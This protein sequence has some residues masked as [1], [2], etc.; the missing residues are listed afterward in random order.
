MEGG[1]IRVGEVVYKVG[2]EIGNGA[3][4]V[5]Y[6][7]KCETNSPTDSSSFAIKKILQNSRYKVLPSSPPLLILFYIFYL[8]LIDCFI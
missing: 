7:A 2:K 1:R 3:F 6:F 8:F 4:G 5:V